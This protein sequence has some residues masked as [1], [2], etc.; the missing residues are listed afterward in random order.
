MLSNTSCVFYNGDTPKI[1]KVDMLNSNIAIFWT[2]IFEWYVIRCGSKN[3]HQNY[4]CL[5]EIGLGSKIANCSRFI[6][7]H[8]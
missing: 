8:N 5:K 4:M 6:S 2:P 3:I 1:S 7:Q